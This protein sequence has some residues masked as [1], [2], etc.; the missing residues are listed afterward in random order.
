MFDPALAHYAHLGSRIILVLLLLTSVV[1]VG[2]YL[3]RVRYYRRRLTSHG[4]HLVYQLAAQRSRSQV[5]EVLTAHPS[6]ET[7]LLLRSLDADAAH[8][9]SRVDG[10]VGVER[11]RWTRHLDVFAWLSSSAPM[12]GLL[13]TI[14]GLMRSFTDLAIANSPEPRIALGGIAD[15]LLTTV[16]GILVAVPA[17]AFF[18]ACKRR[19][20]QASDEV[21]AM[22]DAIVST[23]ILDSEATTRRA[24]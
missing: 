11:S 3:A 22:A 5:E 18:N 12:A 2:L 15:A 13:G 8:F 4:R 24:A 20:K 19:T 23:G 14:L 9:R 7:E 10:F 16:M 1:S 21:G 17:A 6:A